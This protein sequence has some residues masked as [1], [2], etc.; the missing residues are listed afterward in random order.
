MVK[1]KTPVEQRVSLA[2]VMK[3]ANEVLKPYLPLLKKR[4]IEIGKS[5]RF[6]YE[7]GNINSVEQGNKYALDMAKRML[8]IES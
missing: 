4:A 7:V 3:A 2:T 8:D 5:L 6:E 1:S